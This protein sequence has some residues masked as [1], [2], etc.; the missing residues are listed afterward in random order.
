MGWTER[1]CKL[2]GQNILMIDRAEG[3]PFPVDYP[4]ADVTII[5]NQRKQQGCS[6]FCLPNGEI[7]MGRKPRGA[8]ASVTAYM[9]HQLTCPVY[10]RRNG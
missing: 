7:I 4:P 5:S 1:K 2:C 6:P 3:D 8:E 10:N 9:P